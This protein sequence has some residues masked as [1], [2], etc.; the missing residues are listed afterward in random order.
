MS[1]FP[2]KESNLISH[3]AVICFQLQTSLAINGITKGSFVK[4]IRWQVLIKIIVT[5]C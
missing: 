3:E 4:G 2:E 5:Q 1:S